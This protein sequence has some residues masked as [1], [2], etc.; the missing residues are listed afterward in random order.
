MAV[1]VTL[2]ETDLESAEGEGNVIAVTGTDADGNRV[3]FGADFRPFQDLARAL[4]DGTEAEITVDV[5]DWQILS[6]T[7][8][9]AP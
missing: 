9:A 6:T 5:E 8:P 7:P 2:I 4:I 1:A 3:R